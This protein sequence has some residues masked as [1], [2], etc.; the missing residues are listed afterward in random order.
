M[1]GVE[2]HR[3]LK[4]RAMPGVALLFTV[5]C[6]VSGGPF[7]LESAVSAAGAGVAVL[8]I[9]TLPFLWALPDALTSCELAP[10]IPVE[11]GYVIWVRRAMGPFAGFLNAWWTWIY[12]L[13]DA[14]IYPVLFAT[15]LGGFA[16][17]LFGSHALSG[18]MAQWLLAAAMI[19]MFAWLNFR[20][21]RVVG[22]TSVGLA[23]AI[24]LPFV[25]FVV[26]GAARWMSEPVSLQLSLPS[27]GEGMRSSLAAGLG[28]VMWNYLGWD[29]LSTI[30][31]EVEEPQKAYPR[32][33]LFGVGIVTLAYLL[34]TVVGLVFVPDESKWVDGAWPG[35]A[36]TV[37]GSW[38]GYLVSIGAIISP[39]ALF[40][41][42]LLASSRVPLVLAE[43]RFLPQKFSELHPRFGTPWVAI[44]FSAAVFAVLATKTFQQLVTLNV[45]M[46]SCALVLETAA[47]LVLRV[48]EP[49]LHRPFRVP[50]G[51]PVLGLVFLLPVSMAAMLVVL[52]I[53]EEGWSAQAL[54]F[55]A[56][57]SGPL[58]YVGIRLFGS[59]RQ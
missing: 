57:G 19:S 36:A 39:I 58:V 38:L 43:E 13:V 48:R 5:F 31:E 30:A 17:N 45:I 12:T 26:I 54:T 37:G 11:G 59:R 46:Y 32:A 40:T 10:A 29:A 7:G 15:Y 47:L 2:G 6:C 9:A 49:Q 4:R 20:G 24:L 23:L 34:P 16:E 21:T 22:F 50:G 1:S 3:L 33:L 51:W 53:A 35:I 27:S 18:D 42:S 52:S 28:I 44:L 25:L 14:S 41:A 56:I 55:F 8:L